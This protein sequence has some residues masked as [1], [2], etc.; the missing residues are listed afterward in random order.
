MTGWSIVHDTGLS[1]E[2]RGR[3]AEMVI[4]SHWHRA[5]HQTDPIDLLEYAG[6]WMEANGDALLKDLA[7]VA[8]LRERYPIVGGR[9]LKP[10]YTYVWVETKRRNRR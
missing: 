9:R 4:Y 3:G 10:G 1:L 7:L 6:C 8:L 2:E 5:F